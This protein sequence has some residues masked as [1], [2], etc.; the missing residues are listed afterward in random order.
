MQNTILI[1]LLTLLFANPT[2]AEI[3]IKGNGFELSND[4]LKM[5]GENFLIRTDECDEWRKN[6]H[7]N[8]SVHGDD[9]PGKGNKAGHGK[10][11]NKGKGKGQ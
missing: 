5:E 7:D 6:H 11:K 4:C 8:R 10:D 2:T 1:A 9:N 3:T